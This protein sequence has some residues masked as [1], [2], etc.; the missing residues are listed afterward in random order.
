MR[1]TFEHLISLVSII[2]LGLV[3]SWGSLHAVFQV[4]RHC[5]ILEG[6]LFTIISISV[7]NQLADEQKV[8]LSSCVLFLLLSQHRTFQ[9]LGF[10]YLFEIFQGEITDGIAT[11]SIFPRFLN[12]TFLRHCSTR[13]RWNGYH[14]CLLLAQELPHN[15]SSLTCFLLL[16][17]VDWDNFPTVISSQDELVCS[18]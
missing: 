2:K 18:N 8:S 16:L 3:F 4:K 7:F 15:D 13:E 12:I 6:I 9:L 1:W 5:E 17:L 14:V 10:A 11:G